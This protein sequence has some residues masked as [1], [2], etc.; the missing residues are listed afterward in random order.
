MRK[1]SPN[2]TVP[3]QWRPL[4]ELIEA[5]GCRITD[6]IKTRHLHIKLVDAQN[7]EHKLVVAATASDH[8]YLKNVRTHLRHLINGHYDAN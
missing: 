2:P 7:K 5:E 6:F 4:K 3:K 8:R 1:R